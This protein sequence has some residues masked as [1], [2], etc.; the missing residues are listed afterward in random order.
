MKRKLRI[1]NGA[2]KLYCALICC[3]SRRKKTG[4]KQLKIQSSVEI[5]ITERKLTDS[6]A[7][8]LCLFLCACSSFSIASSTKKSAYSCISMVKKTMCVFFLFFATSPWIIVDVS[9]GEKKNGARIKPSI[10][11]VC[12]IVIFV[13]KTLCKHTRHTNGKQKA[14]RLAEK[15]NWD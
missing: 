4:N 11:L 1:Q 5:K 15:K 9:S 6:L 10:D 7:D 13:Y 8:H 14:A 3:K 12:H 2:C